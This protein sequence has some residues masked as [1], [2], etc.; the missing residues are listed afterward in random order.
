MLNMFNLKN[1]SKV[2]VFNLSRKNE[3]NTFFKNQYIKY[4]FSEAAKKEADTKGKTSFIY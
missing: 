3:M 2:I 1:I 4:Q